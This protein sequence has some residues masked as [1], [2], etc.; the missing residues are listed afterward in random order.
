MTLC[1]LPVFKNDYWFKATFPFGAVETFK[2]K[3]SVVVESSSLENISSLA[4]S[5]VKK[6]HSKIRDNSAYKDKENDRKRSR[7]VVTR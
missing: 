3:N 1:Q 7:K 6:N 4:S 2:K 5:S